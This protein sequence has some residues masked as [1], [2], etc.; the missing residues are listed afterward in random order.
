[1]KPPAMIRRYL[2]PVVLVSLLAAGC[3]STPRY[4]RRIYDRYAQMVAE[5]SRAKP[6]PTTDTASAPAVKAADTSDSSRAPVARAN[7]E[8]V[9]PTPETQA[10]PRATP[11]A[12]AKPAA[13]AP[14]ATEPLSAPPAPVQVLAPPPVAAPPPSPE[15]TADL[16]VEEPSP[17]SAANDGVAYMLKQGDVV[18]VS[19][20]GIPNA[21]AIEIVI[22]ENGMITLPFINE[23]P[24]AG[25][26]SSELARNIRQ[27]YL[28][29][30]IYRNISVSIAVPT[31]FYFV[32]GE[33]RQ[34]GRFQ[35]I[36]AIRV[37]QALAGA[38]G[39]TEFASGKVLIKR[40]GKIVK[41]I[42]NARRLERSPEDD[43]WVEPDDI[44][45]VQRSFW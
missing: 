39:Y 3:S 16:D 11:V 25:Q 27:V 17:A 5:R 26:T 15:P 30:G 40:G 31:R 2:M 42:R 19:L 21:E 44:I 12:T 29:E 13:S 4:N 22:D 34:P 20:R 41:T 24:A 32:Q 36:S 18:Q 28:D 8:T 43:I 7:P 14:P 38:G 33:I 9:K 6:T 1:M 45:E 23:V 37:S 10:A 35:L